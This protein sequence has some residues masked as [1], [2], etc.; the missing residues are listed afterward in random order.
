MQGADF[1]L[2]D[3][4]LSFSDLVSK[5]LQ[6][7]FE[8]KHLY[9]SVT[10]D[11]LPLEEQIKRV[12]G[13]PYPSSIQSKGETQEEAD[14]RVQRPLRE[15]L[16]KIISSPWQFDTESQP[17]DLPPGKLGDGKAP[18]PCFR[19]PTIRV[20]CNF[21]DGVLPPHNSGFRDEKTLVYGVVVGYDKGQVCQVFTFPFQCQSCF[22]DQGEPIF[23]LVRREGLKFTITGRSHFPE[24]AIPK[25][26]PKEESRYFRDAII[27]HTA[28]QTLAAL[29]L[30]RVF[31][32]QYMRRVTHT[33]E[34]IRGEELADKYSSLLPSD[35]PPKFNSLKR[36]YEELSEHL[37]SA[38]V[39]VK[40]FDSSRKAIEEHFDMLKL[41]PLRTDGAGNP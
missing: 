19:I 28:G 1:A 13:S 24:V 29:F 21:C 35:F 31:I 27:G 4:E 3:V 15:H 12:K 10:I 20:A 32:E 34:R 18:L 5:N 17:L 16:S 8:T 2:G 23:Y 11:P 41:L 6:T 25:S 26:L 40:Q 14:R 36:V 22:K 30:L 38:D 37:H 9:Q 7:L 33:T 39:S